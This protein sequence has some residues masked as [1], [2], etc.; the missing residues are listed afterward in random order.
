MSAIES[1]ACEYHE[2]SVLQARWRVWR[3]RLKQR[4]LER[5]KLLIA[6]R[7]ARLQNK[8]KAINFW[9]HYALHYRYSV[10]FLVLRS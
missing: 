7:F 3:D 6:D 4:R 1:R 9:K 10:L 2:L 8:Q 5:V